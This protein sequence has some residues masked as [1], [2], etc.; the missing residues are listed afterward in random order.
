M[1]HYQDNPSLK[2]FIEEIQSRNI[3]IVVEDGW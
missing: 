1:Q 3:Q 2:T